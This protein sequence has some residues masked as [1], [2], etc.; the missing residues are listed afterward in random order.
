MST[1]LY[2]FHAHQK[3]KYSKICTQILP[4]KSIIHSTKKNIILIQYFSWWQYCSGAD[5]NIV[6]DPQPKSPKQQYIKSSSSL[7]T[8]HRPRQPNHMGLRATAWGGII[9]EW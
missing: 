9:G 7:K 1:L 3:S 5:G 2:I 4:Q 8:H 6:Q